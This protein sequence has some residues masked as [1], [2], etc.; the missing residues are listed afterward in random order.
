MHGLEDSIA[1]QVGG[2]GAGA[3]HDMHMHIE[4]SGSLLV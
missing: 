4:F 2:E 1:V 3:A